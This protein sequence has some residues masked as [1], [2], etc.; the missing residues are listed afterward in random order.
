MLFQYHFYVILPTFHAAHI[1]IRRQ[2]RRPSIE[3]DND[4][5]SRTGD[6]D[7]QKYS[8]EAAPLVG[9][10]FFGIFRVRRCACTATTAG[11]MVDEHVFVLLRGDDRYIL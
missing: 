7:G 3:P 5:L 4:N 6:R 10:G 11:A 1:N 8:V 9:C 2:Q